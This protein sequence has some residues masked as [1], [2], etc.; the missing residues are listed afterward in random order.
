[1]NGM[2]GDDVS[3]SG[4]F[5]L[6][7]FRTSALAKLLNVLPLPALLL[8]N[9][10]SVVFINEAGKSMV[11]NHEEYVGRTITSLIPYPDH[12]Q[13]ALTLLDKVNVEKGLHV[14]EFAMGTSENPIW[15]RVRLRSLRL[16]RDRMILMLVEDLTN[17]KK[18]YRLIKGQEEK[19]RSARDTLEQKVQERTSDLLLTNEHLKEEIVLRQRAQM[20]YRTIFETAPVAIFEEDFSVLKAALDDLKSRGITDIK[21]YLRTN[22]DFPS[23]AVKL[24]KVV[25][26]NESAIRLFRAEKKQQLLGSVSKV[27]VPE[28]LPA[29]K[30]QLIAIAEGRTYFEAETVNRTLGGDLIDIFLRLIIPPEN[31]AFKNMLITKLDITERKKTEAALGSAKLEW[32]RTFDAVPDLISIIDTQNRILRV[33]KAMADK[34]GVNSEDVVGKHCYE[35]F[36]E[37]QTPPALCPHR[38]LLKDGNEHLAE[39]VEKK[40]NGYFLVS[41]TPLT[42]AKGDLMGCVH[43]ARDITQRKKLE[44]DLQYQA[45]RDSLTNLYN[46]RQ[47]LD[48]LKTECISAERYSTPLSLAICDLD[49][50]K[51]INDHYGHL[52]GDQALVT[53]AKILAKQ[54]RGSD[55]AGRFGGDEFVIAFPHTPSSGAAESMERVRAILEDF[56]FTNSNAGFKVTCTAGI[57]EFAPDVNTTQSLIHA[58]DSAL[59]EA[60]ALG[61][62]RVVVSATP[63]AHQLQ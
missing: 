34:V 43:V 54:L 55:F 44:E 36:H 10:Q 17:E 30:D 29:F 2:L 6:R 23:R 25:D 7:G 33:N 15:G 20:K 47:F 56:T 16:G 21:E 60:K 28:S 50:F 13:L 26:V 27:F 42:N 32:E 14:H 57:S 58:A 63:A 37:T 62:N 31:S 8:N 45:T 4:S 19:L 40:W 5:D 46:R 12:A 38:E 59:Y 61:R 1:V 24:I 41:V 18:Q 11:P 9:K 49:N 51:G 53:F 35:L 48:L 22:P 3:S 39:I 52:V